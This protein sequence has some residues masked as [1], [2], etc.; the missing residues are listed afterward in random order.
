[1][2][3]YLKYLHSGM[4]QHEINLKIIISD[5]FYSQLVEI[6]IYQTKKCRPYTR[7]L[8]MNESLETIIKIPALGSE[9]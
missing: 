8:Y 3:V 9:T 4:Y 2:K 6:Q 1:M 7:N 5:L